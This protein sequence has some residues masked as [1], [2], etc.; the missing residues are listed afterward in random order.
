MWIIYEQRIGRCNRKFHE[1]WF[2]TV[3]Y[4]NPYNCISLSNSYE[5]HFDEIISYVT[6]FKQKQYIV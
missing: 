4:N 2:D 1:I 3:Y 5:K 6:A